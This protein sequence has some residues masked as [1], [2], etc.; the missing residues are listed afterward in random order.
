MKNYKTL[1]QTIYKR[2]SVRAYSKTPADILE[3]DVDF[4]RDFEIQPLIDGIKVKIKILGAEEVNNRRS[5]YCIAFYSEKK[6][7]YLENI[8]FI[9]Q[10]MELELQSKGLGTCW[11]GL[12]KPKKDYKN[13]DGLDCVITMTAGYP[14]NAETRNYPGGY[15]RKTFNEITIGRTA[16]SSEESPDSLI[17]AAR[18]APSA[19]N[20]QPWLIEKTGNRYDFF[21]R[22]QKN[23]IE[24]IIKDIR[25]IDMGI[26]MAHLFVQA[27]ADGASV[28]FGFEGKDA[29]Q[30]KYI[31]SIFV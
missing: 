26:A 2:K 13:A 30:G 6:P 18:I 1:A 8:G 17:E 10:Q 20:L 9:G 31:A 24:K 27:K 12:K 16:Q 28:T 23:I 11:W 15:K 4:I 14:K 7:L 29:K 3:G 21:I 5:D 19:V 25:H 22:P